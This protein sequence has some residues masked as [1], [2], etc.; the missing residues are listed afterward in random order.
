MTPFEPKSIYVAISRSDGSLSIMAYLVMARGHVLPKGGAWLNEK[1]GIWTRRATDELIAEEVQKA[2]DSTPEHGAAVSWRVVKPG[3]VPADRT[4]RDALTDDGKKIQ[5]DM[6]RAREVHRQHIRKRR[7]T[8]LRE[9]DGQWM[10]ATGRGNAAEAKRIE[11][12]RQKWRDM[13]ADARIEAAQTVEEL[14]KLT[15][16]L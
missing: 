7:A 10:R 14:K 4:Y 2:C 3:E 13:P 12:E 16:V 6:P 5:H 15:E 9:L 1:T 11:G 8:V